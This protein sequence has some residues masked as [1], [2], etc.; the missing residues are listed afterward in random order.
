MTVSA[1]LSPD[2][3]D[4][5]PLTASEFYDGHLDWSSFDLNFH[6][7]TGTINDRRFKTIVQ[8]TIPAPVTFRGAPA[9][10]YWEIEDGRVQ[11][12]VNGVGPTDLAQMLMIEYASSYG[13]DWFVVP[14]ELEVG[15]LT[16]VN[17]FVVTDSFG[18]QTLV[19]PIGDRELPKPHWSMFQLAHLRKPGEELISSVERNLFFLP[20]AL[21]RSLSSAATEDVLFMRDEMANVAWAIERAIESPLEQPLTLTG[22]T[23]KQENADHVGAA[24]PPVDALPRYQLATTVPTNWVPLL[25]VQIEKEGSPGKILQRLKRGAMLQ[26]DGTNIIHRARGRILD[27]GNDTL[28]FDQEIPRE[29]IHVTQHYQLARWLDGSTWLWLSNR[30]AVGRGEGSSGLRFDSVDESSVPPND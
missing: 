24:P 27:F 21:G 25:P 9:A 1:R 26:P 29:G 5:R 30:K 11:L 12:G 10:R 23:A 4:E 16:R 18:V 2:P 13:N 17:S 22:E 14:F 15:S 19:R 28:L 7:N 3:F 20:P 6:I 8:T